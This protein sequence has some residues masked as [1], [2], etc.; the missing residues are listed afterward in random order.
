ML[1][2]LNERS[3]QYRSEYSHRNNSE[4]KFSCSITPI[5]PGML[6]SPHLGDNTA[7]DCLPV[8]M[9]TDRTNLQAS[10]HLLV[11]QITFG[12]TNGVDDAD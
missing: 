12:E 6:Q 9:N 1:R 10:I 8:D 3:R 11:Q 4:N 5:S 2:T 7:D